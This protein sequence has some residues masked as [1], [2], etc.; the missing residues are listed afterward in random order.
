MKKCSFIR[1]DKKDVEN[2]CP[3]GLPITEGCGHAGA[4]ISNMCP[5]E[6]VE[7]SKRERVKKANSRVYLYY[8][9]GNKCLYAANVI[10]KY[11]AVNCNFG[12]TAQGMPTPAL[13]G[14]PIFP[15][16]FA[17]VGTD[18][19]YG[20]P[21]GFYGDNNESRNLF[22]GLFSLVGSKGFEI[23]KEAILDNDKMKSI[24]DKIEDGEKLTTEEFL[25]VSSA[26]ESCREKF[27][28]NRSDSPKLVELDN[29]WNSH[30]K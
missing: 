4:C 23:I 20:F 2:R 8:A 17:G 3:F 10:E 30:R 11:K 25:L 26:L 5:L 19:L 15:Q 28:D 18:G 13:S 21:L 14:S 22:Q 9:D 24:M 6:M 12:D 16:T 7:E 1:S 29:R 27:E